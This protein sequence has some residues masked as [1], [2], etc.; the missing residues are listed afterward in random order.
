VN[1]QFEV[2]MD[3]NERI[4]IRLRDGT[5]MHIPRAWTSA[6]GVAEAKPSVHDGVFSVDSL[7]GLLRVLDGLLRAD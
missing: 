2:L 5:S 6:D 3:G 7:R 1:E 4:V